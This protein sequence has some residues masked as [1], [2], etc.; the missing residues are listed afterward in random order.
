ML[1]YLY[2]NTQVYSNIGRGAYSMILKK[3]HISNFKMFEDIDFEFKP[4]FNLILGD[5]GVG[6]TTILEAIT[7]AVSGFLAGMEDVNTRNIYKDDVHYQIVKDNNGIPNK[8]Y[9]ENVEIGSTIN[10]EGLDYTWSRMKRT[11]SGSSR[12]AINPREILK[13]SRDLINSTEHTVLPLISYQSA[14]RHWIS[15]RSDANEKKRKQ[16]HNRRCGYLGCMDKT[17]NLYSIN[18]WCAQMEWGS[19][20]MN[21]ISENYQQFGKIVAKFMSI[22]NDGAISEV[23]FNPN[24]ESLLYCENGEYKTIDDLSAGYQSVLNLI[25]DLAYRMAIL[26]PDEGDN[27]P[28]AEGIVLIDEIDSNL[29]PKWQWRIIEALTETFPNVQFIA[30]THSPII[31]SSCKNANSICIDEE[32]NIRYIGDSYAFSVNEILKDMLGYYMRPAKV[33]DLIEKFGKSMD[34]EEYAQ[35]K[36]VLEQLTE[37][38]GKEHPEIIALESEYETEAEE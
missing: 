13:V 31:V 29:H 28:N 10:Y 32:Q 26:N 7:V 15:A 36:N 34:R 6:K 5:N 2:G 27:I 24:S 9:K 12:T 3:L 19:V 22:M 14:S 37:L 17:A 38:L 21:H 35:A 4:G 16:L 23:I 18:N 20:R 1:I 25:L 30:A 8:I 33:E 11:V